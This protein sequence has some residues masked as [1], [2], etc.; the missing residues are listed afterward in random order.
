MRLF[1]PIFLF[2][3]QK[4]FIESHQ[5]VLKINTK[6]RLSAQQSLKSIKMICLRKP[7]ICKHWVKLNKEGGLS[8]IIPLSNIGRLKAQHVS[9]WLFLSLSP[10][11]GL[12]SN[13]RG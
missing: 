12:C 4:Y 2:K 8:E 7:S 10:S 5:Y 13:H 9:Q 3:I 1:T 6:F 11:I